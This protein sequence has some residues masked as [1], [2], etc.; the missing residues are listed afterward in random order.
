MCTQEQGLGSEGS[1]QE[2][3]ALRRS[4]DPACEAGSCS[5]ASGSLQ[6]ETLPDTL[7]AVVTATS[8]SSVTGPP[9]C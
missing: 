9:A 7:Y 4:P 8:S 6:P 3:E 2:T 5:E 1:S